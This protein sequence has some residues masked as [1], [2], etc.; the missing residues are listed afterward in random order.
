LFLSSL[1]LAVNWRV[2]F[3]PRLAELET[4]LRCIGCRRLHDRLPLELDHEV[5]DL[6]T[7]AVW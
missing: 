4:G 1:S 3:E 6:E 2:R 7:N 5:A